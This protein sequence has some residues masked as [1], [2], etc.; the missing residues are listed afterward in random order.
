MAISAPPRAAPETLD[1][2]PIPGRDEDF[3][4]ATI[5]VAED[6]PDS[7]EALRMLLEAFGY[8]VVLAGN[9][10]EAVDR[11]L[12][13]QPELVLMDV[14]MPEVDG[15]EATRR[16]R[17]SAEFRQVPIVALTAMEGAASLSREAGCDDCVAKP[18]DIRSFLGK[19]RNWL[20]RSP[21]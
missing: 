11:A 10:R 5:L 18:I 14:M 19:I 2:A 13:T 20:E 16:L 4:A 9:G 12:R 8:Q 15:L 3:R 17:A 6:H 21:R 1:S 7:R